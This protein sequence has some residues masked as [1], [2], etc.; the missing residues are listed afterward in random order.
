LVS[1]LLNIIFSANQTFDE[2]K[3]QNSSIYLT[4]NSQ[5]LIKEQNINEIIFITFLIKSRIIE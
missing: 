2:Q 1:L 4:I 3:H 5:I